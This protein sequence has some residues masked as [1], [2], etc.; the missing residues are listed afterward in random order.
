[1][2]GQGGNAFRH[3]AIYGGF[4]GLILLGSLVSFPILTRVLTVAEYGTLALA[5]TTIIIMI[6][7]AKSG[8]ATS[9]LRH[10]AEALE[11]GPDAVT[12]L[13]ATTFW[14]I[15]SI[16][17]VLSILFATGVVTTGVGE[18]LMSDELLLVVGVV[19]VSGAFRDMAYA[20]YRAEESAL[21]ANAVW[22][23]FKLGGVVGGLSLMAVSEDRVKGFL[24]GMLIVE[25]LV[26]IYAWGRYFRR[27]L[28]RFSRTSMSVVRTMLVYGL[29]LLVYESAYLLNDYV[30]RYLVA[31]MLGLE[32][33]GIYS[34]GYNLGTYVQ[35]I[36]I[37]PMWLAIFPIYTRMWES[38]GKEATELFLANGLKIYAAIACGVML[39]V[40]V[41]G[42]EL[43]RILAS[44]KFA[45]S[46]W[47]FQILTGVLLFHGTSH[48]LCAGFH[49]KRKTTYMAVLTTL[50]A[51]INVVLN[52]FLIP[53]I[54]VAG[55]VYSSVGSFV[56]LTLSLALFGRQFVQVKVA[57]TKISLYVTTTAILAFAISRVAID[58][59]IVSFFVHSA[60]AAASYLVVLYLADSEI[61]KSL[62]QA[63][64]WGISR[65]TPAQ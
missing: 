12:Q 43:V 51:V 3:A 57:W 45:G 47:I 20:F 62:Q 22:T 46:G 5:N 30:D 41:S 26:G 55:A 16:A 10:H 64:K 23:A 14:T 63:Y 40:I 61:R 19:F 35:A 11:K 4:Q 32:S 50:A 28:L 42:P 1:M 48:F 13:C 54:G 56:F 49:L 31:S 39:L 58:N 34:V 8:A 6:A 2:S 18:S 37:A 38:E 9:F 15:S 52:L 44:E 60:L 36:F 27:G 25:V 17:L 29:P 21:R 59:M 7:L 53:R 33:V 24:L 65:L